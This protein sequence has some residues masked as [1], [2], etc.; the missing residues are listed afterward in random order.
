MY[1]RCLLR[2]STHATTTIAAIVAMETSR[3][4]MDT[5]LAKLWPELFPPPGAVG[6]VVL[7][8]I[9]QYSAVVT[10]ASSLYAARRR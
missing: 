8:S 5:G 2:Q 4:R 10:P 6:S 3:G 7:L 9:F 1:V